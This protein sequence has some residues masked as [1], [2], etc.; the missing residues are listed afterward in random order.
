[1]TVRSGVL[2]ASGGDSV[3][4]D[5][6]IFY[7]NGRSLPLGYV[8]DRTIAA[9]SED[10]GDVVSESCDGRKYPLRFKQS[11]AITLQGLEAVVPKGDVL[12]AYD[13]R[14]EKDFAWV[15]PVESVR[16]RVEGILYSAY[17]RKAG[18]DAYGGTEMNHG[19]RA[20]DFIS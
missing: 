5:G 2:I 8:P 17:I 9:F 16:G 12:A 13:N 10:R 7:V 1:M 19:R 20:G 15:M 11:P 14:L 6:N 3:R 18:A 4:Y